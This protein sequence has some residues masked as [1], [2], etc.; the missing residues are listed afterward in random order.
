MKYETHL[1]ML[2]IIYFILLRRLSEIKLKA[3]KR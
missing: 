3:L 2:S 1:L